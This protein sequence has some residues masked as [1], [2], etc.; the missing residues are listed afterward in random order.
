MP[1]MAALSPDWSRPKARHQSSRDEPSAGRLRVILVGNYIFDR[2][3][4]MQRFANLL[5]HELQRFADITILA[6]QPFF[7][8]LKPSASGLG[9]WLGYLDKFVLFPLT[10]RRQIK[11]YQRNPGHPLVVHLC[12]Q[13][14]SHYTR[15]LK[16]VPHVVTCHDLLAVRMARGEFGA[17]RVRFS[18]RLY[19]R[20]IADGLRQAGH[21]I[22]VSA[23]TKEDVVRIL[24]RSADEVGVVH[25]GLNYPYAPLPVTVARERASHFL[26]QTPGESAAPYILHVGGNHWYKNRAG[27]LHLFATLRSQCQRA[28]IRCPK[29]VMVGPSPDA[30]L[31]QVVRDHAEWRDDLIFTGPLEN[32][33]LC[34][35]YSA[36]ELLLFPSFEEGFGWPI[37]EAQA[38]GCRVVTTGKAP[39][40]EIGGDAAVYLSPKDVGSLSDGGDPAKAAR[41]ILELLQEPPAAHAERIAAGLNNVARF[42]NDRMVKSYL[43]LYR[44]LTSIPKCTPNPSHSAVSSRDL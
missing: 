36:A 4:S 41:L 1:Q 42:S 31:E 13:S 34:A 27:V 21:I 39:M 15:Y 11:A 5:A 30:P 25:N 8:K 37:I 23:A 9:K 38:C 6:P 16:D 14:N 20:I 26:P 43:H 3:E 18:G 40:N 35:L 7:G 2:Q 33:D 32:E 44:N 17:G 12:D 29:L 24:A 10:L 22:C 19:Q 28:G